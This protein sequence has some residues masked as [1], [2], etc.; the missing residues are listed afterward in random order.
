L[1]G[2]AGGEG[3]TKANYALRLQAS[4]KGEAERVARSEGTT[5]NQFINVAVAEKLSA[6]RTVE[7]FRER[8]SRG[9]VRR[10]LELL[11][12]AGDEPPRAGDGIEEVD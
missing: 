12:R 6:L 3:V 2:L 9:D 10:A 1:A 11:D 4:L 8:A 5:L 7:Y